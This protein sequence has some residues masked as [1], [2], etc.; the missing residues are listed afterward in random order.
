MFKLNIVCTGTLKEK[1]FISAQEEYLK[2]LQKFCEVKI[3]EFAE[4]KLPQNPSRAEIE[5][6][7]DKEY[8]KYQPIL[9]GK[10][11]VCAVEG[12]EYSSEDFSKLLKKSFDETGVITFLIG[13]SH[14]LSQNA[15]CGATLVSFSKM[16]LPHHLARIFLE[17]QIYRAF[18]ILAGSSYHK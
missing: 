2:R 3:V 16:T 17:E 5:K 10:V 8:E 7:L 14:G 11:F 18:S 13:S 1:H 9:K 12:K 6:A 4:E 15:K